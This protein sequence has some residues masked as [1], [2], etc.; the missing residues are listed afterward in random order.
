MKIVFYDSKPYDIKSFEKQNSQYDFKFKF[1]EYRLNEDT[2]SFSSGYDVVCVFVNDVINKEV[3]DILYENGVK[4]LAL[5]CAG[6]NNVDFKAA[7]G[8]IHIIRVPAYSPYAVAEHAMALIMTLNRKTHKAYIRT[9]E[10]NFSLNGLIGFTLHGKTIGV[11]GTGRIG[12]VFI[13]I[14]R[15]IGMKVI[16]YDPYPVKNS[17]IDYV[18]LEELYHQSDIISLHCPLTKETRHLINEESI[19][20]MKDGIMLINT[21]RGGLVNTKDL[22]EGLKNRKILSAALD[23]YEEESD[24]FFEDFSSEIIDDD[25]LARLLSMPNVL[26][27][28]HQAF[29]TAE[30]LE[31]IAM[32]TLDGISAFRNNLP[33]DNEICYDCTHDKENCMKQTKGK[34]F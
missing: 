2:A 15:G 34:C 11:I 12:K 13:D 29:F 33:L 22:I 1:L 28:S 31:A 25:I 21:S 3:I 8:K 23:V 9:R 24:Y 10:S 14:C 18:S 27:T 26:I 17:D 4:L 16:A 6:Y 30:A 19:K 32:T 20:K 7:F 5:R